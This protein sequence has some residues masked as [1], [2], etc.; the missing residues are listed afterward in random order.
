[1]K[2]A[3][4]LAWIFAAPVAFPNGLDCELQFTECARKE[5]FRDF[6]H[7]AFDQCTATRSPEAPPPPPA[8][9]QPQA[10]APTMPQNV[11]P[12]FYQSYQASA[13][14][15][16]AQPQVIY[17]NAPAP[18]D[19]SAAAEE[20]DRAED[21]RDLI[22]MVALLQSGIFDVKAPEPAITAAPIAEPTTAPET[23]PEPAA[24]TKTKKQKQKN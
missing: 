5:V 23:E 7:F 21:R 4:I 12:P 3:I 8:F 9:Y 20:N 22:L 2:T 10:E 14:M 19:D 11:T 1:M 16:S 17:L 15:Q 18:Q 6:C 13:P 24:E